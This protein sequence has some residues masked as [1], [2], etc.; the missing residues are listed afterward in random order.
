MVF[1]SGDFNKIKELMMKY[2]LI[3]GKQNV[4]KFKMNRE[5]T[6]TQLLGYFDVETC[7]SQ[8]IDPEIFSGIQKQKKMRSKII[9]DSQK[10]FC[11][12]IERE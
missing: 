9:V 1:S 5:E 12:S 6:I 11:G 7:Q 3:E 8:G 2:S 10:K 4:K